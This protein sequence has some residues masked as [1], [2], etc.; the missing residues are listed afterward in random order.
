MMDF[1]DEGGEENTNGIEEAYLNCRS[2]RILAKRGQHRKK[3]SEE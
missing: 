2:R 1:H 3:D